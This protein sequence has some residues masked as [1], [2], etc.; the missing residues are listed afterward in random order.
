MGGAYGPHGAIYHTAG[1]APVGLGQGPYVAP[2]Y[3]L[4]AHVAM[5]LQARVPPGMLPLGVKGGALAS[6]G[7]PAAPQ[8]GGA[9][10]VAAGKKGKSRKGAKAAAT[11][12]APAEYPGG[13]PVHQLGT[14]QS[15]YVPSQV[16]APAGTSLE[17]LGGARHLPVTRPQPPHLRPITDAEARQM[18]QSL[19][20]LE[21]VASQLDSRVRTT[22]KQSLLR[23][24][25]G[26]VARNP[27][28]EGNTVIP[29]PAGPDDLPSEAT[30]N[31][32]RCI[33]GLLY[34]PQS[35]AAGPQEAS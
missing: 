22:M 31:V 9:R 13:V 28:V 27:G 12:A 24:S 14:F 23:L 30:R 10:G 20:N 26:W 35:R 16:L 17:G 3:A 6:S 19:Q 21:N 7:K 18:G 5:P 34:Y 8:K 11:A 2:G 29:A 25:R 4:G 15:P 1:G 33:A 32:D